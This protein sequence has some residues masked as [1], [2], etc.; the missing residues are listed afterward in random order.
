MKRKSKHD[1]NPW[2]AINDDTGLMG[3]F[4]DSESEADMDDSASKRGSRTDLEPEDRVKSAERLSQSGL[5]ESEEIEL[6]EEININRPVTE[7]KVRPIDFSSPGK[8]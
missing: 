6:E 4:S 5:P 2:I 8:C 7:Q 3:K 1:S